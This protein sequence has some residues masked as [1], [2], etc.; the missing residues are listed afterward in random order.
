MTADSTVRSQDSNN[1]SDSKETKSSKISE[2]T[3]ASKPDSCLDSKHSKDALIDSRQKAAQQQQL[4]QHT[5]QEPKDDS[6]ILMFTS[7]GQL[8]LGVVLVVFGVLTLVHGASLGGTGAGLW[9]GA[10]ALVAGALGVVATLSTNTDGRASSGFSSAHLA[11]SL[12]ALAMSNMAAITAL[13]AVVRDTQRSPPDVTLLTLPDD[14]NVDIEE[15]WAGLLAS[16]GLL[17]T[18]AAELFVSG[19]TCVTLAPKLCDC[20]R[21]GNDDGEEI[22]VDGKTLKTRNM[23]HQWVIAQNHVPKN[24]PIYV[25]QPV[26]PVHRIMQSPYGM[27]PAPGKYAGGFLTSVPPGAVPVPMIYPPV[28][29]PSQIIRSKQQKKR[30][31]SAD[32]S[33]SERHRRS[34]SNSSPEDRQ[35]RTSNKQQPMASIGEADVARTYT[36]L[37]K[38]M[39]EEFIA[40][41]MDPE[42]KS[43]ASSHHGSEV[44]AAHK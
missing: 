3:R 9:A 43:K 28:R 39:S 11:S 38:R 5:K 26:M 23:V 2:S 1:S 37:D 19:Y 14:D 25:V 7:C 21:P 27:H 17:I 6:G 13:T 4:Q 22:I 40:I 10:S 44:N 30:R 29:P 18:S 31:H 32:Q 8:L 41:A 16:I 15:G 24:Q 36:G 42:R 34:S 35:S 20:L 33:D 12:V